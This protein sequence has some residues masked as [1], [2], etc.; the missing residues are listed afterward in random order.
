MNIKFIKKIIIKFTKKYYVL[1]FLLFSVILVLPILTFFISYV[2]IKK[3]ALNFDFSNIL[4]YLGT[5]FSG[6]GTLY[7]GYISYKINKNMLKDEKD[8]FKIQNEPVLRYA[9]IG[10]ETS[11]DDVK[12][13]I[14]YFNISNNVMIELYC[15]KIV[16]YDEKNKIISIDK[17]KKLISGIINPYNQQVSFEKNCSMFTIKYYEFNI[18]NGANRKIEIYHSYQDRFE[19]KFHIHGPINLKNETERFNKMINKHK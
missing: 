14:V 10:V 12:V 7:L 17:N 16:V 3:F 11:K 18:K 1:I 4:L 5:M 13:K 15:T 6:V 8:K 19:K 2:L 9:I